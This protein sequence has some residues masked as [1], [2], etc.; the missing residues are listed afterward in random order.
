[1]TNTSTISMTFLGEKVAFRYNL[2][3]AA[4]DGWLQDAVEGTSIPQQLAKIALWWDVLDEQGRPLLPPDYEMDRVAAWRTIFSS[5]PTS[6]LACIY[7]Q[8]IEDMCSIRSAKA[9]EVFRAFGFDINQPKGR[10]PRTSRSK[11]R[12]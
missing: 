10:E 6:L 8:V 2:A 4:A 11:R 7:Q 3:A 1:M 5:I 9:R 12:H